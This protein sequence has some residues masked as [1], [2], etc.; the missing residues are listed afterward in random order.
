MYDL[1]QAFR[2]DG[3]GELY[4]IVNNFDEASG[5]A[6]VQPGSG[7]SRRHLPLPTAV[8]DNSLHVY[9]S[10]QMADLIVPRR[11]PTVTFV[12][13]HSQ[14]PADSDTLTDIAELGHL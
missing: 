5:I 11:G 6:S 8:Q 7:H 13:S 1:V 9:L 12:V 2:H 4:N 10:V 14:L 3:L